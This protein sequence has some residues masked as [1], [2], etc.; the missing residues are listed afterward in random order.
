MA[1][2]IG[3]STATYE[4]AKKIIQEAPEHLK[5]KVRSGKTSITYAYKSVMRSKDHKAE[6]VPKLPEAKNEA[7]KEAITIDVDGREETAV[8][9][10]SSEPV[11]SGTHTR[12]GTVPSCRYT[13]LCQPVAVDI[14]GII[15]LSN[16]L[17]RVEERLSKLVYDCLSTMTSSSDQ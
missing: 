10:P 17:T 11:M 7:E 4:H 6:N 12:E 3:V 9:L 15:R 1:K 14:S 13:V 5:Q 16:A 8:P 2:K